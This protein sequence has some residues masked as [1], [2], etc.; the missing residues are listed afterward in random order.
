MGT[1]GVKGKAMTLKVRGDA[2][3]N[4]NSGM[5][6]PALPSLRLS[7]GI[8]TNCWDMTWPIAHGVC[9]NRYNIARKV[10]EVLKNKDKHTTK[11]N[12]ISGERHTMKERWEAWQIE[13]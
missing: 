3:E 4:K 13:H 2:T 9:A 11:H 6:N 7:P 10:T 5:S 12:Q 1:V 8:S